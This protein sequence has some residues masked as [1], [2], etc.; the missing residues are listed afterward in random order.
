MNRLALFR[1]KKCQ[2][3]LKY[4]LSNNTKHGSSGSIEAHARV[5]LEQ[6][7]DLSS[8]SIVSLIKSIKRLNNIDLNKIFSYASLSEFNEKR[9][10][11]LNALKKKSI[12]AFQ[13]FIS[14]PTR[15]LWSGECRYPEIPSFCL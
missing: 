12:E 13:P 10:L 9:C 6:S 14:Y 11:R 4:I 5:V 8:N 3:P 1:F 2:F 7:S 15:T